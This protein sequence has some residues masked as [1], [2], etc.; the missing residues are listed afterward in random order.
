V[1]AAMIFGEIPTIH[2]DRD[3]IKQCCGTS[4]ARIF[5]QKNRKTYQLETQTA[6]E[7]RNS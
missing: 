6:T 2:H 1:L 7:Q 5:N 3:E 4:A